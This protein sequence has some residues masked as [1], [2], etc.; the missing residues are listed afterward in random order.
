MTQYTVTAARTRI[1]VARVSVGRLDPDFL[2][3]ETIT[4]YSRGRRWGGKTGR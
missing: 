1:R 2:R 3:R 4:V